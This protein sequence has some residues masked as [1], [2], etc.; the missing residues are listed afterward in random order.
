MYIDD[1]GF[2]L[3][4]I[5]Y[6][7]KSF[8]AHLFTASRG[9]AAFMISS[10]RSKRAGTSA[11]LFQPLSFLSFQWD[12]KPTATL[13]RMKDARLLF[14]QQEIPYHPIKRSI[15]MVL[16]E[17][18][19]LA[20]NNEAEN[21]DLYNYTEHSMLWLDNA[22]VRYAN[23]HLVFLLKLSRFLGIAPNMEDYHE[24]SMLDLTHGR[25]TLSDT[26]SHTV[27]DAT[28]TQK[29]YLLAKSNYESM[30]SINMNRHDRARL[31]QHIATYF[32]LHIP[33]FPGITS[34][35]ILSELFED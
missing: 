20:L 10:S 14:V 30:A 22:P 1:K 23:F 25:F 5:K 35:D 19:A 17:F 21:G 26:P 33:H 6:D 2:V 18:M 24:G 8:I 31:T 13:H 11:R 7:D 27:L 3:R 29:L 34:L 28:D 32:S 16:T 15:A 9:H 4:T 12:A